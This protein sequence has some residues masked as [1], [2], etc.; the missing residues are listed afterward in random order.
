MHGASGWSYVGKVA[1]VFVCK[2][3]GLACQARHAHTHKSGC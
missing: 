2:E 3:S 1:I